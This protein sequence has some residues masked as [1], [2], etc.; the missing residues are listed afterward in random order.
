MMWLS[1]YPP[2]SFSWAR[3]YLPDL[4]HSRC[5]RRRRPRHPIRRA[6]LCT[7]E[8]QPVHTQP[9][10]APAILKKLSVLFLPYHLLLHVS[11]LGGPFRLTSSQIEVGKSPGEGRA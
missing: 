6:V 1:R 3:S 11:D 2:G 5:L 8:D 7:S 9:G 4:H 10:G